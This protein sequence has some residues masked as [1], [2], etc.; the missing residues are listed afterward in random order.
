MNEI[1]LTESDISVLSSWISKQSEYILHNSKSEEASRPPAIRVIGC[2]LSLRTSYERVVKP[3]L[4]TFMLNHPDIV[5]VRELEKLI[6][7]YPSPYYFIQ[8]ELNFSSKRKAEMLLQVVK[9]VC[10]IIDKTPNVAEVDSLK[11]WADEVKPQECYNLNIKYFK[12][13][14]FQYL[15]MLFGAD[16][17]KPDIH[18]R[19]FLSELLNRDVSAIESI[20]LLEKASKREKIPVRA[21][22][23]FIWKKGSNSSTLVDNAEINYKQSHENEESL[24]ED[25]SQRKQEKQYVAK[26]ITVTLEPDVA[27]A[28]P[29]EESVNE[30]LRFALRI[31]SEAKSYS[32]N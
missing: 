19:N 27:A 22:D 2:V 5:N 32:K 11:K 29:T 15:R 23:I 13:A 6:E 21:V 17:A 31:L 28:F 30:A 3:R 18:V 4:E 9:Y 26:T 1:R 10:Q 14:G 24:H 8:R 12:L 7:S 25:N 20:L 16:T